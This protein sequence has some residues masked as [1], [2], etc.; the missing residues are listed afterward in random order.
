MGAGTVLLVEA[1]AQVRHMLARALRGAGYGVLE[2]ERA[3]NG[4]DVIA[5]EPLA[6]CIIEIA[7]DNDLAG[8]A[9]ARAI[10]AADAAMP[11][12]HI[13]AIDAWGLPG[14]VEEDHLT[15]YLC[16]PFGV[17]ALIEVIGRLS[18]RA[19]QLRGMPERY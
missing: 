2:A 3:G 8:V 12:I 9:L 19:G 11:I 15:R 13:S 16:K 1:H 6:A 17:R 7:A 4:A 14:D 10:R 18:D 5:G